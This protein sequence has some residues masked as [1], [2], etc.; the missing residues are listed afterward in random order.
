MF[1]TPPLTG[2]PPPPPVELC[3]LAPFVVPPP[4]ALA[5]SA[6]EVTAAPASKRV[7]A[8]IHFLLRKICVDRR[9]QRKGTPRRRRAGTG[10][11]LGQWTSSAQAGPTTQADKQHDCDLAGMLFPALGSVRRAPAVPRADQAVRSGR[12]PSMAARVP[13]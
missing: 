1:S 5:K 3:G 4:H 9:D 10:S 2:V 6:S 13:A 7:L 12:V 11:F 8:R